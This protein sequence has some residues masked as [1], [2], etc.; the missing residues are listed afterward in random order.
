MEYGFDSGLLVLARLIGLQ[1][2]SITDII[3]PCQV[4]GEKMTIFP[5]QD[6]SILENEFFVMIDISSWL[7]MIIAKK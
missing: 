4:Q 3:P 6:V 1:N 7:L 5:L 2:L